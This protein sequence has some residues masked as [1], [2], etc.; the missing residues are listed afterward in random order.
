[1]TTAL[2]IRGLKKV[3]EAARQ[4][5][6]NIVAL[7]GVDLSVQAREIVCIV[8]PSGCGKSTLL[9]LIAGFTQPT[10]GSLDV[11]GKHVGGP[12]PDRGVVFQAPVLFPWLSVKGNVMLGP[13]SAGVDLTALAEKTGHVLQSVGLGDFGDHY[14]YQL[15][16][17]MRQRAQIARVLVASPSIMLMDEPFGALDAQ[18]RM[19]MHELLLSVWSE[20]KPTIIFITHD[21]EE[22]I[23]LADR[24]VVMEAR[25]GR[26]GKI[27]NVP[28]ERPRTYDIMSDARFIALRKDIIEMLRQEGH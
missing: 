7:E 22:A 13:K 10:L 6:R 5:E 3:F 21:V 1:M 16:G 8:G 27:H 2:E 12:S 19:S 20:Y 11:Y 14:P 18:T 23:F 17:G 25:P 24:V 28:F 15:S 26:I 9:D 4:P